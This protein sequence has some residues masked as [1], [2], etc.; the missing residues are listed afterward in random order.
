MAGRSQ[1]EKHPW[2]ERLVGTS[3]GVFKGQKNR[4]LWLD[5]VSGGQRG[6]E[7]ERWP[8]LWDPWEEF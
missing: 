4:F 2:A 3:L 5:P 6:D 8:G 1:E 7:A